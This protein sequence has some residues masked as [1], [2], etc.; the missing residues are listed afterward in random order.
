MEYSASND[1]QLTWKEG[2]SSSLD[3]YGSIDRLLKKA[4]I[5]REEWRDAERR[6]V[7]EGLA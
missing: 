4:I 6:D 2:L 1:A 5:M 3:T 7:M